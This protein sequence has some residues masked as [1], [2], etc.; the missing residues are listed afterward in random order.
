M[1]L[2]LSVTFTGLE[3]HTSLIHNMFF[4]YNESRMLYSTGPGVDVTDN[5][6]H[7]RVLWINYSCQNFYSAGV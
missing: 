1:P 3:K 6:K 7:N 2:L 5:D 4:I